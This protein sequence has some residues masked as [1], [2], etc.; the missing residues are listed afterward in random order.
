MLKILANRF[1]L[2]IGLVSLIFY[3]CDKDELIEKPPHL[4][5]SETLYVNLS[6]FDAGLNGLYALVRM[7]R[8][9]GNGARLE[10]FMNGTDDLTPNSDSKDIGNWGEIPRFWGDRL[11]AEDVAVRNH[12]RWLYSVVNAANTI[13]S[14]AEDESIDWTGDGNSPADNKARVI[15]EARALRAWAYRHLSGSWG[16]VPLNL[17]E[18]KG[19]NIKTDW[20]RTPV[21]EVRRQIISDLLF[22]E[23]H[24]PVERS[25]RGRLTKGAVQHYLA[26]MY[27]YFNKPDSTLF[28][29]NKVIDNPAYKLITERYG[30]RKN[31]PGVPVHDMWYEGN[32]N[33]D[34]GNTEALW[35]FQFALQ[36][37]GGGSSSGGWR[38]IHASRYADIVIGGVRP[39]R[40][41]YERGGRGGTRMS[42]TNWAINNYEPQDHRASPFAMRKFFILKN[43]AANAPYPAD[44]L[45]P[46]YQYGDTIW[47]DWGPVGVNELSNSNRINVRRPFMRKVEGCDPSNPDLDGGQFNDQTYLRL[48][49]TYLLKAEA[50]F[51]LNRLQDA[52]N[53]LNV[54]RKRSNATEITASQVDIDFI[55]DERSRELVTEEHRRYTL[56]RT[57]KLIER[58]RKYNFNGGQFITERDQLYP[59]PQEV[60]DANLT[61]PM[62]Q[63]PGFK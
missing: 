5:T 55:L 48:A 31:Q 63:N 22:A 60:I 8:E 27:L 37:I 33:R 29:A 38:R 14:R 11:N 50:E 20:V 43:A 57:G 36:T 51:L 41:T 45:P 53:T 58:A 17:E 35:V 32:E 4:I 56:I 54:I 23:K 16:D 52:A 25:W 21:A 10:I 61:L 15:A 2:M 7:E 6:G 26:E 12:F 62:P 40:N 3:S 46:G 44:R 49:E 30:V 59:I 19:S 18:S 47:C 39:L 24:I 1:L 9:G 42:L 13:I 34:Q 28:W